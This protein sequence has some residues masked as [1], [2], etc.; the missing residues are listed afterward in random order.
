M[1]KTARGTRNP[2]KELRKTLNRIIYESDVL[3]E[4]EKSTLYELI[5]DRDRCPTLSAK[6]ILSEWRNILSLKEKNT[7]LVALRQVKES[8]EPVQYGPVYTPQ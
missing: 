1:V 2:H 5:K 3:L 7:I 4:P 6:T 8:R